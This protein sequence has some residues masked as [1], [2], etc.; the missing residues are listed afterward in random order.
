MGT[1]FSEDA[2]FNQIQGENVGV[3]YQCI[4]LCCISLLLKMCHKL[5]RTCLCP[6]CSCSYSDCSSS[7]AFFEDVDATVRLTATI[8]EAGTLGTSAG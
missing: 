1:N 6:R 4:K 5:Q 8:V 7:D 3:L 2:L